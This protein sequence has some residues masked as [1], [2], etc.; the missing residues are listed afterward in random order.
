MESGANTKVDILN[1][2]PEEIVEKVFEF[3]D[4]T[5]LKNSSLVCKR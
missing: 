3:L 5:D 1:Q 2:L 4:S